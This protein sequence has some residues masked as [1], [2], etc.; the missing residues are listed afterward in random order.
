MNGASEFHHIVDGIVPPDTGE[1]TLGC[2]LYQIVES[3][4]GG[5]FSM[6]SSPEKEIKR[7]ANVTEPSYPR[8]GL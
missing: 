5:H 6:M 4:G 1:S 2:G 7:F 3:P 8:G